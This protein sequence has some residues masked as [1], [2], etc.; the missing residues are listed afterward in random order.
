MK[1]IHLVN[2][3]SKMATGIVMRLSTGSSTA[4]RILICVVAHSILV[5]GSKQS[6]ALPQIQESARSSAQGPRIKDGPDRGLFRDLLDADQIEISAVPDPIT[7]PSNLAGVTSATGQ[8]AVSVQP[9]LQ[10]GHGNESG[11]STAQMFL[12]SS[13]GSNSGSLSTN[14]STYQLQHSSVVRFEQ[15]LQETY[16]NRLTTVLSADQRYLR[17][18]LPTLTE[19]Q[20]EMQLDRHTGVLVYEGDSRLQPSWYQLM[21]Q[22]DSHSVSLAD[23]STSQAVF[24]FPGNTDY[25]TVRQTAYELGMLQVQDTPVLP[26]N[27]QDP[28]LPQVDEQLKGNVQIIQ[29]P[30]TGLI[31][32]SYEYEEDREVMERYFLRLKLALEGKQKKSETFAL[33]NVQ[34]ATIEERVK[35]LY[36]AAYQSTLGEIEVKANPL[37]NSLIVVGLPDAIKQVESIIAQFD[38]PGDPVALENLKT[39][40]LKHLSAAD[41]KSRLDA[42]FLQSAQGL[43]A[44]TE[45]LPSIPIVTIPDFRSN[46]IA[47]KGSAKSIKEAEMFLTAIDVENSDA[48][49]E[50]KVIKIRN[51]LASELALIVQDAINGQQFGAGNG[52]KGL[53]LQGQQQQQQQ[54]QQQINPNAST[55]GSKSLVMQSQ[56]GTEGPVSSGIM[57][58]V[59]V[60]ADESSNSLIISAPPGSMTL[61]ERLILELDRVPDVEV[62]MKVFHIVNGDAIELLNTLNTLFGGNQQQQ[63]QGFGQQNFGQQGNLLN[64]LPLQTA[65]STP[66]SN[67]VNLR[68]SADPRTNTIIA[69]GPVG[70]L[71]VVEALL[72]RLDENQANNLITQ[73]YRLSNAPALD[74]ADTIS[75]WISGRDDINTIDPKATGNLNQTI[76]RVIVVPEIVSNSLL[77]Q[78]H[79]DYMEEI[80]E[81]IRAIDRR[82]PMVKVKVLLAEVDLNR[83]EEFGMDLGIQDS[84]LFDRGTTIGAGNAITGG[85]GFPFN[86]SGAASTANAN[87]F[88]RENLAG[89]ALSN[90]GTGRLNSELGYGGFVLSAGNESVS[91]LLRALEN[92]RCIRVLSKPHITTLENL[93]GRVQVGANVP[94]IA[95]TIVNGLNV[96][97]DIEFQDVGVILEVTPRVS[98]DGMIVLN[99][100]ASR[101]AVGPEAEGITVGVGADGTPIRSPQ[102][103][104]TIATTTLMSRSGQT[105]VFGGLIQEAK[106]HEHRGVPILS[107]LPVIGPLFTFESDRANRSELLVIMTPYIITDDNDIEQQNQEEMD[108][109]HWCL[110]D[111]AEIYGNTGHQIYDGSESAVETIY[112]DNNV[113]GESIDPNSNVT[114]EPVSN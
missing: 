109:M 45:R 37:N 104:Q 29:D 38:T 41:A 64:Q 112:P 63:Q 13:R 61:I 86:S 10:S 55:L 80:I 31:Q 103:E 93:Q 17:V 84:I 75:Q 42:Y 99:V 33:K 25:E 60:T 113:T 105:V 58:D 48:Q 108:R 79:P 46:T 90:L 4:L 66:G 95:G 32:F 39:F 71:E 91:F 52:F 94:R 85:I 22:L 30:N 5:A 6:W 92:K 68:F 47:V 114:D 83:L 81:A 59:R 98:P 8:Q 51:R 7:S 11:R 69:T 24:L 9:F 87:T 106:S 21:R 44:G 57:F 34:A 70:E 50:I 101:S 43:G 18:A 26:G 15:V 62:Q 3:E 36:D 35:E 77:I 96:T 100:N 76:R 1:R 74:I 65:G 72:N 28:Q 40:R 67:L 107:D 12:P 27:R 73:V 111:V 2:Q 88:G 110:E 97:Q 54:Q 53:Q 56:D 19:N 14:A 82:P 89:Q 16:S 78:A 102:I 23:G 20:L 49:H